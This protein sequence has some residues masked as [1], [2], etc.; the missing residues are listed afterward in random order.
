MSVVAA[1][2]VP[3]PP[4]AVA[5]VGRG[6]EQKISA[7]L[8]AFREV[9]R[10]IAA[11]KPDVLVFSSP[12]A[13]AYLDYL[14]IS[15]G[16]HAR[17]DFSQFGDPGDSFEVDY[18]AELVDRVCREAR[19]HGVPAG[20]S[21]ERDRALDHGVMVP[22]SFIE[23]EGVRRPI[24]RIGISG[25]SPLLHYRLGECVE[26]ACRD[27]GR[28]A[29]WVAS[30]DLSHK[31]LAEGPYG[32][33]PQ[34]PVFD[35]LV[36]DAFAKGDFGALMRIPRDV[37]ESAAECGLRSF[38]M[39]A[40]AFDGR[41][42]TAEL[43]SHEGPYGVGYGV[44]A[45]VAV[46][47]DTGNEDDED[48]RFGK[49]YEAWRRAELDRTRAAEDPWVALSR[50]SLETWVREGRRLDV[51]SYIA[52]HPDLPA[53]LTQGRAGAF[54]SLKKDGELRGCIGT[55]GP[56]QPSLARE[57][58]EN[59]VSAGTRDPRFE[60]VDE[61]ELD[62]LVYSVDVLGT[63]EAIDSPA[64]LDPARWGV[65]VSARDGRRGLLLPDLEGVDTV[66]QQVSIARRKAGIGE[67]EPVSLQ[68]FEVVRHR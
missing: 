32:F 17:G 2:A 47:G 51:A 26:R 10:R 46:G 45:F 44:A 53:E 23:A 64:S 12:H 25:L 5:G 14:H 49:A 55:T 3:H 24:V 38:Q 41:A 62:D 67:R 22:L 30:G 65:I 11:L 6:Q 48:R 36:C 60:P 56:T 42:V 18:D 15:P 52:E 27:L 33:D 19:E 9:G 37:A 50:A 63:P 57:I 68:R 4:L 31:L 28:R 35:E 7:T 20:T 21:G 39:M 40:G 58:V 54:C 29:V 16:T 66:E 8:E 1:F 59:A 43:L 61:D 34:G 13:T